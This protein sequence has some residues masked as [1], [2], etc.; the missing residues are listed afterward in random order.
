LRRDRQQAQQ[1]QAQVVPQLARRN[2][3][4]HPQRP[5]P[6]HAP[7]VGGGFNVPQAAPPGAVQAIAQQL[8]AHRV[9]HTGWLTQA[10]SHPPPPQQQQHMQ[11][12]P[13]QRQQWRQ[14]QTSNSV[15]EELV[16]LCND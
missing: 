12:P 7:S 11:P 2:P 5:A 15:G 9:A 16:D 8:L 3:Q 13:A 10:G 6:T 4:W 14:S 1:Q